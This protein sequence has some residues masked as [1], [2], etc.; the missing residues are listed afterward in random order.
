MLFDN[1][2]HSEDCICRTNDIL[3]SIT[4]HLSGRQSC[5]GVVYRIAIG[6]YDMEQASCRDSWRSYHDCDDCIFFDTNTK[7]RSNSGRMI[8]A[9]QHIMIEHFPDVWAGI[10]NGNQVQIHTMMLIPGIYEYRKSTTGKYRK[11]FKVR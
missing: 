10:A 4:Q 9:I 5:R 11:W 2:T 6:M 7:L 3:K 1:T 8:P